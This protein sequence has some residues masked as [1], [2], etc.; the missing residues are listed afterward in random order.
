MPRPE[1]L[2]ACAPRGRGNI[3]H[4]PR[5]PN[6]Q[7][8]Q[9]FHSNA[10]A[11]SD[12]VRRRRAHKILRLPPVSFAAA[13]SRAH[14]VSLGGRCRVRPVQNARVA[15]GLQPR[16]RRVRAHCAWKDTSK[17]FFS[18]AVLVTPKVSRLQPSCVP[19][20]ASPRPCPVSSESA[21]GRK[22][23]DRTPRHARTASRHR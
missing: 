15:D 18:W 3:S 6:S 10:R 19:G 22:L 13:A 12:D 20:R 16:F 11:R 4:R 1:H 7:H 23:R 9:R 21:E 17:I 14:D 8:F 5:V 2:G